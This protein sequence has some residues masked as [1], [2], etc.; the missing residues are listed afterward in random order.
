MAELANRM[1]LLYHLARLQ[2]P[3]VTL[4]R[5][6]FRQ[7]LKRMFG[8]ANEKIAGLTLEEYLSKVYAVDS[9][10]AAACLEGEEA[11]WAYLFAARA[12]SAEHLLLDALRKRAARLFPRDLDRQENA[13]AD[14][15]SR[16]LIPETPG[17]LPILARYDGLRPLV[18]WLIR[19]FQN[20]HVSRLR[21]PN[22]QVTHLPDDELF[23]LPTSVSE[24]DPVQQLRWHEVFREAAS[25]W[26]ATLPDEELLLLGLRWR[27][28]LSQRQIAQLL[29]V[30]E[31]TIS[32]RLSHL[33]DCCLDY[34]ARRLEDAGW[35]D[36]DL[37]PLIEHEMAQVLFDSP[38]CSAPALA[39]LLAARGLAVPQDSAIS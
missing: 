14:F 17:S 18:P 36:E 11:A 16:L 31:G 7:H 13:L 30:H 20:W 32:R 23:T 25:C 39:H 28:R 27:Y 4:G 38:R 2:L 21:S 12:G 33:R 22:E 35:T 19:S 34:L 15:W 8:L 24:P 5:E 10:L 37:T 9:L 26:L 3:R 6:Q 29:G 1:D